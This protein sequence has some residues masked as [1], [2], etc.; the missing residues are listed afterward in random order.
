MSLDDQ[1]IQEVKMARPVSVVDLW[2]AKD[3][4]DRLEDVTV[5]LEAVLDGFTLLFREA[6]VQGL[7]AVFNEILKKRDRNGSEYKKE[8]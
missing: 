3:F 2:E 5:R 7:E 1:D 4:L 6:R 8:Y